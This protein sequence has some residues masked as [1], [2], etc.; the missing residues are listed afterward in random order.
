MFI[1]LR[2]WARSDSS[3][4]GI[5]ESL[6]G[7]ACAVSFCSLLLVFPLGVDGMLLPTFRMELIIPLV[8]TFW[9]QF[10]GFT[11][12]WTFLSALLSIKLTINVGHHKA[13][14]CQPDS[15]TFFL[16][17]QHS[18]HHSKY[19]CESHVANVIH[20]FPRGHKVLR[21]SILFKSPVWCLLWDLGQTCCHEHFL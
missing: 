13:I 2:T 3:P 18:A 1:A 20:L 12:R 16:K 14:P 8:N 17:W 5:G 9:E 15:Q 6:R 4:D 21:I 10:Y 7:N 11:W 19:L